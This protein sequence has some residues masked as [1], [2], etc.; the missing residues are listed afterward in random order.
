MSL[1]ELRQEC[2]LIVQESNERW[3]GIPQKLKEVK[4][5]A[6]PVKQGYPVSV[7]D[8]N[9]ELVA[10]YPSIKDA[11]KYSGITHRMVVK[12]CDLH[13]FIDTKY[14]RLRFDR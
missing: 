7:Y 5:S 1:D 10:E 11:A 4:I 12:S 6:P 8:E 9:G 13:V 14:G 2:Q 3:K